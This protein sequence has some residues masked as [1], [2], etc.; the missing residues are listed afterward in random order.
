MKAALHPKHFLIGILFLFT[1][2]VYSQTTADTLILLANQKLYKVN[3]NNGGVNPYLNISNFPAA[4]PFSLDWSES[5]SCYYGI[6]VPLGN[7]IFRISETGVYTTLGA[8]NVPG[9][10]IS[11]MEGIAF[12][13][14]DN[15]L[16]ASVSLNGGASQGDYCSETLIRINTATMQG[17][18]IG[19]FSH[20]TTN[21][22]ESEADAI[23]FD[24]QGVLYYFDC[25]VNS[26]SRVFKQDMA[27]ANPPV[28]LCQDSYYSMTDLTVRDNTIFISRGSG[29]YIINSCP[30]T[31]GS[32]QTV[33]VSSAGFPSGTQ[34]RGITWKPEDCTQM[35]VASFTATD[36]TTGYPGLTVHFSN[37]SQNA[38]SFVFEFAPNLTTS[39]TDVTEI[40][41]ATFTQPGIYPVVLTASN[42]SCSDTD[43]IYVTILAPDPGTEPEPQPENASIANSFTPNGDGINDEFFLP[44]PDALKIHVDI[45]N[46]WG[47]RVAELNAPTEK[48]DG[49]IN[50]DPASEGVY[51]FTYQ[52]TLPTNIQLTGHH[53]LTLI[54]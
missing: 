23:E 53:F 54:R 3:K 45:V 24:E 40:V 18:I 28:L 26:D 25:S 39:T 52:V 2:L 46:R 21:A 30:V 9:Y 29:A 48:W 36:A 5:Q 14:Q 20:P 50:G 47:N 15:Q 27:F 35:P 1:G 38:T 34:L 43:T 8:V 12:N 32:L 7:S 22:I 10:T 31:G 33:L 44:F 19:V 41:S 16:Y 42:G 6:Q 51:F 17:Q 49:R 11:V 4:D 13:P 37:S